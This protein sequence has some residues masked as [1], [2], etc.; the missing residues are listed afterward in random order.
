M[1]NPLRSNHMEARKLGNAKD[2]TSR[3]R[4]SVGRVLDIGAWAVVGAVIPFMIYAWVA[5]DEEEKVPV[6]MELEAPCH[7][8]EVALEVTFPSIYQAKDGFRLKCVDW[9]EREGKGWHL[10]T[11]LSVN[12]YDDKQGD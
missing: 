5:H 7:P 9:G 1:F 3:S 10:E 11:I 2:S 12:R 4:W 8:G 6:T